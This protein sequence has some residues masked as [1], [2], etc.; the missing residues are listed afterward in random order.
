[1]TQILK[2]PHCGSISAYDL[3]EINLDLV[4]SYVSCYNCVETIPLITEDIIIGNTDEKTHSKEM[5]PV[6]E[7]GETIVIVN[8]EHPWNG[9][10]ALVCGVKHKHYRIEIFGK[11]IWVPFE[12]VRP[13]DEF[14]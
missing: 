10:L 11:R 9:E 5:F 1:M 4:E 7:K 12:W 2:C 8:E 6:L 3:S 14:I 13:T